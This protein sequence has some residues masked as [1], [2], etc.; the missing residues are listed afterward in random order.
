[1]TQPL[2]PTTSEVNRA[3]VPVRANV[4][5]AVRLTRSPRQ[6]QR[7]R[8]VRGVVVTASLASVLTAGAIAVTQATPDAVNH[9]AVCYSEASTASESTTV[10]TIV[11]TDNETGVSERPE[12]L[13][14]VDACD[15]MWRLGIIGQA[16]IPDDPNAANLPVPALVGCKQNNGVGAAFPRE[17]LPDSA[18]KACQSL[19]MAVWTE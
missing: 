1:M 14:P 7:F 8:L 17:T 6:S 5:S 11:S 10:S 12:I 19:G 16:E 2:D 13:S 3:L 18:V 9:T 4:L 15:D